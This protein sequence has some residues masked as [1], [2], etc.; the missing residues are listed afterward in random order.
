MSESHISVTVHSV[1]S[2]IN[3]KIFNYI[4]VN[5]M[6]CKIYFLLINIHK[7][8]TVYTLSHIDIMNNVDNM[9]ILAKLYYQKYQWKFFWNFFSVYLLC[10]T[11]LFN[12]LD[13]LEKVFDS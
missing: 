6:T 12:L 2:V 8:D 4:C 3:Q 9:N 5:I 11:A 7:L 1:K 13:L 10:D